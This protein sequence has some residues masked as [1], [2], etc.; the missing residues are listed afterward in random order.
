MT[1]LLQIDN[2]PCVLPEIPSEAKHRM[3]I[4]KVGDLL[5]WVAEDNEQLRDI[6]IVVKIEQLIGPRIKVITT[7]RSTQFST[8]PLSLSHNVFDLRESCFYS[9]NLTF[10]NKEGE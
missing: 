4:P 5:L 8:A 3:R 9:D 6:G 1:I 10:L 2:A 7:W